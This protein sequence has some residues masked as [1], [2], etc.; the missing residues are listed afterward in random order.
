M[1]HWDEELRYYKERYYKEVYRVAFDAHN[2]T[3]L[4]LVR[5]AIKRQLVSL[6]RNAS[7]WFEV[8]RLNTSIPD[9]YR[10]I[11]MTVCDSRVLL[12]CGR[13]QKLYVFN[14]SAEHTLRDAGSVLVESKFFKLEC[15]RRE[16]D[17]LVPFSHFNWVSLQWLAS[18]PLRLE[19]LASVDLTDPFWLLF[20]GELLLAAAWNDTTQTHT[21]VSFSAKATRSLSGE[22]SSTLSTMLP[23]APGLSRASDLFSWMGTHWTCSSS[24]SCEHRICESSSQKEQTPKQLGLLYIQYTEDSLESLYTLLHR[25]FRPLCSIFLLVLITTFVFF[26]NYFLHHLIIFNNYVNSLNMLPCYALHRSC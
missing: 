11:D 10:S 3:L 20:R 1:K 18:L 7:E 17:T 5:K 21:I 9:I 4:L 24:I 22:W 23:W 13:M 16:N 8:H 26:N 2:K 12:R 14:V 6:R 15:T 25:C 19:P